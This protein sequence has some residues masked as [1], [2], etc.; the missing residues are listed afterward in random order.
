MYK[1]LQTQGT[2]QQSRLNGV[3]AR[4][5]L[6]AGRRKRTVYSILH[7]PSP[8]VRHWLNPSQ[9]SMDRIIYKLENGP[10]AEFLDAIGTKVWRVFLL[11]T[12]YS[13]S[14]LLRILPPRPPSK[15]GLKL[16]CII[17]PV[18]RNTKYE[19]SQKIMPRNLNKFVRSWIRL[20]INKYLPPYSPYVCEW[21]DRLCAGLLRYLRPLRQVL[22]G[23]QG[24]ARR[25]SYREYPHMFTSHLSF[26]F[27]I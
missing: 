9:A 24:R 12:L 1:E 18:Y 7:L 21:V 6:S 14:P 13:Q 17:N 20:L 25:T 5:I 27:Y 22:P 23:T 2:L 10:E 26:V 11:A 15:S 3:V 19:N 4:V 16:V 8:Q